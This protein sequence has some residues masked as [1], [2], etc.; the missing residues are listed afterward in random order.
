[1]RFFKSITL[2]LIILSLSLAQ[3]SLSL[4]DFDADSGTVD[5]YMVND[6][7]VGGF[8]FQISGFSSFSTS[9][10]SAADA[11]FTISTGG[12]TILGFSFSGASIP[13]G[14]GVLTTISG[15][16]LTISALSESL[17]VSE[18]HKMTV[19]TFFS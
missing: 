1:M 4:T 13:P 6:A 3:I 18:S 12:S 2:T 11:G 5:V 14:E 17:V 10:G 7:A 9:G 19:S 16:T 15:T 8:Q